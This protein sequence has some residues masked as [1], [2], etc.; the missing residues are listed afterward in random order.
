MQ[1]E[2]GLIDGQRA[3]K[4]ASFDGQGPVQQCPVVRIGDENLMYV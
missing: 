2:R 1:C 3:M 4:A